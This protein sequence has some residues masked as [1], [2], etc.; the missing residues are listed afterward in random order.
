MSMK[1]TRKTPYYYINST[2]EIDYTVDNNSDIDKMR[3]RIGNYFNEKEAREAQ[4]KFLRLFKKET[5]IDK[6]KN[7]YEYKR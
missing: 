2:G 3:Y 5:I 4:K 7:W 6:I 1:R